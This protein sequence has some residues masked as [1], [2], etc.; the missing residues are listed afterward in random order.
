MVITARNYGRFLR[1]CLESVLSRQMSSPAEVVIVD[2]GSTDE[3]PAV[4][5]TFLHDP[6]VSYM[7]L[8]GIGLSGAAN[9]GIGKLAT[10]W[11]LRLDADDWLPPDSL[12]ALLQGAKASNADFVW[13]DLQL[14]DSRGFPLGR[15]SQN[16]DIIGAGMIRSPAGSGCLFKRRLW[17]RV[18]GYDETLRFQEDFDFWLKVTEQSD[19]AHVDREVYAYRQHAGTMSTNVRARSAARRDVKRRALTRR[20]IGI[21]ERV[22]FCISTSLPLACRGAVS[23]ALERIGNETL[24]DRLEE[25]IRK[26]GIASD[27]VVEASS[28]AI[29]E[30]AKSRGLALAQ[31]PPGAVLTRGA[32]TIAHTLGHPSTLLVAIS[33]YFPFLDPERIAESVETALLG[34]HERVDTV[35]AVPFPHLVQMANGWQEHGGS[36][37]PMGSLSLSGGVSVFAH[38][39]RGRGFVQVFFPEGMAVTDS[40]SLKAAQALVAGAPELVHN[41][42]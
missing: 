14:T 27:I 2:D 29:A 41:A 32:E 11:I 34:G 39:G 7:R 38:G 22:A 10:E 40:A 28:P 31:L 15:L 42:R 26:S 19:T 4:A 20:G 13:G 1:Q 3:T 25:K 8:E 18:G 23:A 24:L 12:E 17:E 36:P 9:R 6:R 5:A 21:P 37:S 33:P 35:E 16:P 30:W